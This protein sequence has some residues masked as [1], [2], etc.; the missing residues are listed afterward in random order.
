MG[1]TRRNCPVFGCGR[2]NLV[3]LSNHLNQGMNIEERAKWL[4][5]GKLEICVPQH[6]NNSV[7]S[8][9]DDAM[10]NFDSSTDEEYEKNGPLVGNEK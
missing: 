2:T 3:K 7:S 10:S 9:N 5:R 6:H 8:D 4:K 1:R